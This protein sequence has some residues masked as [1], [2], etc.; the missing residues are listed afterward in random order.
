MYLQYWQLQSK[1]FEP[2]ADAQFYYP[3]EGHQGALFKL[4]YAIE[5]HRGAAVLAG[6]A[7]SGKTLL[8]QILEQQLGEQFAPRL[9]LVFPQMAASELL[10]YLADE[11]HAPLTAA[12]RYTVDES[13]RRLQSFLSDN[14]AQGKHAVVVIDEAHLLEDERA[15]DAL[16]LLL[17]FGGTEGPSLTLILA[18]QPSLLTQ[19][20]RRPELEARLG[21]RCLLERFTLEETFSY[22][23]HRLTVARAARQI[24]EAEAIEALHEFAHG[25]PQQINRLADFSL[26]VGFADELPTIGRTQV[27]AVTHEFGLLHAM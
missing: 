14:T 15:W 5:N 12:P 11:L 22:V 18:G 2:S 19:M 1:P 16:R 6:P 9:R 21:A 27:E 20:E 25:L 23:N 24:F 26:L 8:T 3:C 13:V 4:R 17:N 10:A 7:G